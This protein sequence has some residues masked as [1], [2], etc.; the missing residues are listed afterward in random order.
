MRRLLT[1]VMAG[2]QR[3]D[4][5]LWRRFWDHLHTG[6]LVRGEATAML[7]SLS[8]RAPAPES[9]S[10][11]VRSLAERRPPTTIRFENAV[12]IVGTGGGLRTFNVSTAAA[13][14]AAAQAV[15]VVKTGS[16]AYTSRV[17]SYDL[18][19][20]LGIN[21]TT[22]YDQTADHLTRYDIAFAG[23]FVYPVELAK[24]ARA[25]APLDFRLIGRIVNVLGPFLADVDT[26]AQLTGVS[27]HAL[28]PMLEAL[29]AAASPK[30]VWLSS[31]GLG[32]D[33]LLSFAPNEIRRTD[34]AAPLRLVP[35]MLG[36]DPGTPADLAPAREDS[37]AAA[38]FLALLSGDA[39]PAAVQTVCLN[40][41][42]LIILAGHA[43][44]WQDAFRCS[45]EV[46]ARGHAVALV[47][48][49]RR[50]GERVGHVLR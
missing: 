4:V 3:I 32:A 21:L 47:D 35:A 44:S 8:V 14:V 9:A 20:R 37:L 24:L 48:R 6:D 15:P 28:L 5:A 50:H 22:S 18:L 36:F 25:V 19:R 26:A 2:D 11:L 49:L 12:N 45:A 34:A 41:A 23:P 7:T 38:H 46:I 40:S 17:G 10:A 27:D 33:E 43:G 30:R 39:P 29:A 13:L 16:S 31:N 1:A 42:A